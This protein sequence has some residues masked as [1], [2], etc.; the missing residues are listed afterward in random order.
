MGYIPATPTPMTP[1]PTLA[2]CPTYSP[3]AFAPC[4]HLS[5]SGRALFPAQLRTCLAISSLCGRTLQQNFRRVSGKKGI[6]IIDIY[7][8]PSLCASAFGAFWCSSHS[9]AAIGVLLT[10][11]NTVLSKVKLK[12]QTL[13]SEK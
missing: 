3:V 10:H 12:G 8:C 4:E 13:V 2:P 5:A 1:P 11:S 9:V 6:K 7:L